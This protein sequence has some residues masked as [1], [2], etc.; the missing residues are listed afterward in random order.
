MLAKAAGVPAD[1]IVVDL[2]DAVA[3]REKDAARGLVGRLL[4]EGLGGA[5]VVAVRVNALD[6]GRCHRDVLEVAE[7]GGPARSCVS[8]VRR[9]STRAAARPGCG[10]SCP[11]SGAGASGGRARLAFRGPRRLGKEVV[12]T[13]ILEGMRIVEG[14]AF[15]AVPLGGMTM[16]Q[17]GAEVIRFDPIGGGLDRKRRP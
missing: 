7:Q 10:R 17:L 9:R 8:R 15:V 2:E 12:V 4:R 1:E 6:S 3:P 11:R 13:G 16:A 5:R 14:S